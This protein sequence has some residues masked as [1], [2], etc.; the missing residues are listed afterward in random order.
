M[1]LNQQDRQYDL[2]VFGATGF[3]GVLTT[4]RLAMTMPM[5]RRWA[6]AGR[7]ESKLQAVVDECKRLNPD[8]V[9]PAIE[10]ASIDN[11]EQLHSLATKT[12]LLIST[13]GPYH[14]LGEGAFRACAEAGTHYIDCTGEVPWVL[15]MISKYQETAKK[16]GAI[17]V[18][19]AGVDSVPADVIAWTLARFVRKELDAPIGNVVVSMNGVGLT[20]SGGTLA[21]VLGVQ[22]HY[23]LKYLRSAMKPFALSPIPHPKGAKGRPSMTLLQ[24][25]SG[26]RRFSNHGLVT[27]SPASMADVPIVERSW[28]LL[29]TIP[30]RKAEFYGPNFGFSEYFKPRNWLQGFMM[31]LVLAFGAVMITFVPPFRSLLKMFIF[32]PGQGPSKE[33]MA[34]AWVEYRGTATP[35]SPAAADKVA[36]CRVTF[37]QSLYS[38]TAITLAEAAFTILQGDLGLEGGIYTPA[39]LGPA[40]VD[41]LGESGFAMDV[42]MV[43]N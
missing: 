5:N 35:D 27:T 7:S 33:D 20:P 14:K 38:L 19:Q 37:R 28:G 10:I 31:H 12:A 23:S 36:L 3:T 11:D 13:V 4:E 40:F 21:T 24:K 39:C 1:S 25:L 17:M 43:N 18:P 16:T 22:E 42:T 9:E 8:M 26:L 41:R 29:S 34:K 15:S 30:S 6:V 2:V 32:Q